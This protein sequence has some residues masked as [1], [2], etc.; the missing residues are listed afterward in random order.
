MLSLL[1]PLTLTA[2]I[3][4]A[5]ALQPSQS[6][7]TPPRD[8]A[9]VRQAP[10]TG[11][12]RGRVTAQDTGAPIARATVMLSSSAIRRN[13]GE[14]P[15]VA[16]TD[17]D[18][19][20]EFTGL[21]A[22]EYFLTARPSEFRPLYLP[23][24]LGQDRP[25][26][27]G[28]GRRPQAVRLADGGVHEEANF[29]L[30]R[31]FAVEGR[32]LD[33]FGEPM[34]GVP[35]RPRLAGTNQPIP[36]AGPY[37]FVSDD[38][39][40]YRVYGLPPGSYLLCAS[41]R[42]FGPMNVDIRERYIETCHPAAPA[43]TDAQPVTIVAGD[44]AGVDIRLERSRTFTVSGLALTAS[45]APLARGQVNLV[46]IQRN[47]TGS[48][49]LQV[50]PDGQF[51]ARGLTPGEYAIRADTH[52]RAGPMDEGDADR[53]MAYVT[54]SVDS[55][56]IEGLVVVTRKPAVLP[57]RI[58]VGHGDTLPPDPAGM[59][60]VTMPDPSSRPMMMGP[61]PS[62]LVKTDHTFELR[63]LFGPLTLRVVSA[64]PNWVVESIRFR[65]QDIT[66]VPVDFT[67][68]RDDDR[69]E[70]VLTNRAARV[71][72]A[73]VDG[74]GAGAEGM[75]IIL[76]PADSARWSATLVRRV[77][78]SGPEGAFKLGP[79]RAG[80]YLI[81][82]IDPAEAPMMMPGRQYFERLAAVADRLTLTENDE[83]AV[84]LQVR[85]LQ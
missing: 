57:G 4:Q 51:V 33:E 21:P 25:S 80:D 36:T 6:Q 48:S 66:D 81:V 84:Q 30:W 10:P 32:I 24:A 77:V 3:S 42:Q 37:Q 69:L 11:V 45:G 61:P 54:F 29:A 62:A 35:V 59:R 85:R 72:G 27:P 49:G 39:G 16:A 18:G 75:Q 73:V 70:I 63:N 28:R 76:F 46:R 47:S 74:S 22:G 65:G 50:Q 9:P 34:A 5:T 14:G 44:L 64:P 15:V 8:T 40:L 26:L 52:Q 38:R 2:A 78:P 17:A 58:V 23:L 7:A 67:N 71:S 68:V 12:I 82:A 60:V 53:E 56:D 83:R 55:S 43:D 79:V 13:P 20:Y 1:L 41:P 31:A 19:R